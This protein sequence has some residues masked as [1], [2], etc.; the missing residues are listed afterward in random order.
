MTTDGEIALESDRVRSPPQASG[1]IHPILF[2]PLLSALV[3]S[4]NSLSPSLPTFLLYVTST[5]LRSQWPVWRNEITLPSVIPTSLALA[6]S[7]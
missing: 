5:S 3:F 1:L 7:R 2:F 6:P 4:F